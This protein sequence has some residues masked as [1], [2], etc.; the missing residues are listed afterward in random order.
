MGTKIEGD[1][2]GL[3]S[4][5]C[6]C[7]PPEW[8]LGSLMSRWGCE[9]F[10]S[11]LHGGFEKSRHRVPLQTSLIKIARVGLWSSLHKACGGDSEHPS[12]LAVIDLSEYAGKLQISDTSPLCSQS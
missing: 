2:H 4:V 1:T 11:E 9:L 6:L 8:S 12:K 5:K 7:P 3:D 10:S